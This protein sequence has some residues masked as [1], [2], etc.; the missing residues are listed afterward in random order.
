MSETYEKVRVWEETVVIPTYSVAKADK[1]PL[2]LEKRAY[3]GSSGKVYP[4]PVIDKISDKKEDKE[5]KAVFLENKYLKVM[6]L[7][8]LGGRVQR[9]YDKMRN[10][11]FVYYNQVIKPAL[12]GLAGPWISGGIEFNW[13]QHHRPS[14]FDEV[15][16]T[17]QENN[18]GSAT[19]IVSE[20]E[21]MFHT[22]GETA[23]T[24][25]PDKAYIELKNNL[26]NRTH[27]K[28]TFLWWA[29]PAVAVNK[30]YRSIFPPD[31][32][33]V[34]DH[35][36]RDISTFPIATG[37]YYKVDYSKGV[38]ISKYENLPVPTSYMAAKSD[39]DFVGGYDE[40]VRAGILHIADHHI[41]PGKKQWTWGCGDFG[42]AWDRNLTDEDGPYV[43]L[44]TGCFTD[45]QPDFSYIAPMENR[46]FTQYFLPYHDLGTIHNATK[47]VSLRLD[48]AENIDVNLYVSGSI[49][50][51]DIKIYA[52]QNLIH[53]EQKELCCG[54]TIKLS[55]KNNGYK[56]I[57]ISVQ[58]IKGKQTVLTF[59]GNIKMQDIPDVATAPPEPKDCQTNEDLYLYGLHIEQ[60][61]HAT[62]RA[63]DYYLEGLKR[64]KTDIRLNNAYGMLLL[65]KGYYKES[66]Q[67]FKTAIRKQ[68]RSNPNPVT[69]ESYYNLGLT[70]FYQ[71]R[72]NEAFDAFYKTTW[73]FETG[74][75]AYYYLS[76]IRSIN[77]D[78]TSALDFCE[79]A[80]VLNAHN[81]NALNLKTMLLKALGKSLEALETAKYTVSL[82]PLNIIALIESGSSDWKKQ[83]INSNMLID[84]SL[85]YGAAGLYED[86]LNL[87]S[88]D[89]WSHPL[90]CYYKAYYSHKANKEYHSHLNDAFDK[91][92]YCCFPNRIE[93]ILI[94]QFA[95]SSN[96]KDF[97]APYYLGNLF[98]DKERHEDAISSFE[99]SIKL[100]CNFPTPYRNLSL[101]YYNCKKDKSRALELMTTAFNMDESDRRVLF[102]LDML[103]KK[104]GISVKERLEF[105][106]QHQELVESRDDLFLEYITL[107]NLTGKYETALKLILSHQFHPWEGGEGKVPEQYLFSLVAISLK[108]INAGDIQKGI[109]YLNACFEYPHNLGEGKLYGAQENRQNY[110]LGIAYE[111]LG[112][113]QKAKEHFIKASSGISVPSSAVYYNDQPPETI[114][115]QGMALIKLNKNK[116]AKIRFDNLISYADAHYN[117]ETEIDYFAVS[118]PDL[119]VFEDDL[120]EK[121]QLHCVFMKA[122]GLYGNAEK[123]ESEKLFET[124]LEINCNHFQIATHYQL[125]FKNKEN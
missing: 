55:T 64:D 111:L 49:G 34:M 73:N 90:V 59:D 30:N 81:F 104:I 1:N 24:L 95:K 106:N 119:L 71:D 78:F 82:D 9:A 123:N 76:L 68:T 98:F 33:S 15:N 53:Y 99:E 36:K 5:Y 116:E 103:K 74:G 41:S 16:Y 57:D 67:Y 32:T 62:K 26:F 105:L 51:C 44:M 94:L 2:F 114:F 45:N 86:A 87:L 28:Q 22:K 43:E 83:I 63:E 3:Q 18:D 54:D 61:R 29:N 77:G 69:S 124:M 109:D 56:F 35:G 120:I 13:P 88:N 6:I 4:H 7:P 110:Y 48:V 23:F 58:I 52:N 12:V 125:L 65:K 115:Y 50:L 113:N 14:T 75:R 122:L 19:I 121:N 117:D 25:Y 60:Y 100:G 108:N 112:E 96:P 39:F 70:L 10:Y 66:E 84:L 85:E 97:K 92:S 46:T 8:E 80:L 38:D 72:L 47:D 101:L 37:T 40:G 79:K 89:L 93:D 20:I 102:E 42:K 17:Y 21:N 27:F 91:D 11:D 107:L 31:V 118:L